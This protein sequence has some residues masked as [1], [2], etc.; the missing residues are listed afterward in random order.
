MNKVKSVLGSFALSLMLISCEK[1]QENNVGDPNEASKTF[2]LG[3]YSLVNVISNPSAG[4][5]FSFSGIS[6]DI[7]HTL[8]V[9][10]DG[11]DDFRIHYQPYHNMSG[12]QKVNITL[13]CLNPN[14]EVA[15]NSH[16][17]SS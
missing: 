10:N 13:E 8:D 16:S 7:E 1:Q 11:T 14:M 6:N 3:D 15:A 5:L 17:D 12:G 4:P 9:D 2:T